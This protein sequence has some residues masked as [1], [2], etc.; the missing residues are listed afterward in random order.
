MDQIVTN[1]DL[2]KN[3][4]NEDTLKKNIESLSVTRIIETQK[5][6]SD[7]FIDNFILNDKYQQTHDDEITISKLLNCQ[8]QYKKLIFN[9]SI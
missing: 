1:Q 2:L 5:N 6:L 4:Y 9:F 7:D 8:P 3:Q